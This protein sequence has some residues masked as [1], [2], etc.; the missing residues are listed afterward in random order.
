RIENLAAGTY[1]YD[2]ARHRLV[3]LAEGD[4]INAAL[5]DSVN[6]PV[7][8]EAGFGLF[9]VARLAAIVPLYG[10]RGRHFAA[11]EAG[12]MTQLLETAAPDHRIGLSQVGGVRFEAVRGR[13]AL[14]ESHELV[15]S[16]L[17][18]RLAPAQEG[19]EAFL[20]EAAEYHALV[21]LVGPLEEEPLA[22]AP[23][24]PIR[25]AGDGPV[26]AELRELLRS[27][28]PDYMVPA[29]FLRIEEVP[30]SSNGKVD[31]KALPIPEPLRAREPEAGAAVGG[32]NGSHGSNGGARPAAPPETELEKVLAG[33]VGQVLGVP[34]VGRHDNFFDLGAS[35]VHVVRVHNALRQTLGREVPMVEMFNHPSVALLARHLAGP[36]ASAAAGAE[37]GGANSARTPGEP[38]AALEENRDR[39]DRLR[40]GKDWRKQR[41]QKRQGRS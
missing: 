14:E 30:L 21:G 19:R 36:A 32:E 1:Y 29:H 20:A 9:L 5:Y 40:E 8:E 2:P 7:F 26:F 33:I 12:L 10:E 22:A 31:R 6:H 41:L 37:A 25:P 3:M 23:R 11:L 18:G 15:H 16:L 4:G 27:R 13:L 34:R 24:Q 28:L 39:S 17:G 38:S 35:S